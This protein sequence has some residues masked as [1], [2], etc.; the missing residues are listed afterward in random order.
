MFWGIDGKILMA[1]WEVDTEN[2]SVLFLD[3]NGCF[4][5]WLFNDIICREKTNQISI[6]ND[7]LKC[8]REW[9]LCNIK[10]K[11]NFKMWG[12][13]DMSILNHIF[14]Q[15]PHRRN[16]Y[17]PFQKCQSTTA[18]KAQ[19]VRS[20][21]SVQETDRQNVWTLTVFLLPSPFTPLRPQP[22]GRHQPYSM[23]V[24]A[25]GVHR[26]IQRHTSQPNQ[27]DKINLGK[28]HTC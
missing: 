25:S 3:F 23:Q 8:L 14:M 20:Q 6:S 12:D 11:S 7:I 13:N 24:F 15:I 26:H 1:I 22:T 4:V 28:L 21:Y 10:K 5:S 18:G 2:K 27:I 19:S 17:G 9:C 16:C